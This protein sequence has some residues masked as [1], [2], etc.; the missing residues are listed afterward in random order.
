MCA[1]GWVV[2]L[3]QLKLRFHGLDCI[4][5]HS[6]V[7]QLHVQ[8][9]SRISIKLGMYGDTRK[10]REQKWKAGK[11]H[12][13]MRSPYTILLHTSN[14]KVVLPLS[15]LTNEKALTYCWPTHHRVFHFPITVV[16][17]LK[18]GM[19]MMFLDG[20]WESARN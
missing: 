1:L 17:T 15:V 9:R 14:T 6:W 13:L 7:N 3:E 10:Q 4:S 20:S 18:S 11:W 19:S 8:T 16:K 2:R 12:R 5:L